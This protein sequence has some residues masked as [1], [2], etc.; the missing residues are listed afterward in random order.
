MLPCAAPVRR[1]G[2]ASPKSGTAPKAV[3]P[4]RQGSAPEG[5]VVTDTE[6]NMKPPYEGEVVELRRGLQ[7]VACA[8]RGVGD[9]GDPGG[10]W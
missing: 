2:T 7:G 9:L 10:S 8:Q 5:D 1:R 6:A 4:S 3:V